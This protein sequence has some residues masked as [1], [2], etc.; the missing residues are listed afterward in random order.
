[1]TSACARPSSAI[2]RELTSPAGLVYRYKGLDDGLSGL[3]GTFTICGFRLV[4]NLILLGVLRKART[5]LEKL[6]GY[7]NDLGLISEEVDTDTGEMLGNFPQAFS[8]L[9]F[10]QS[11]VMLHGAEKNAPQARQQP[12]DSRPSR[13][14]GERHR[15]GDTGAFWLVEP[16]APCSR[17]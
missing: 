17:G 9:A 12:S 5:L 11:A 13:G 7:A 6:R 8:H 3:E 16:V 10:N 4:E 15:G 14:K 2:E 1:M